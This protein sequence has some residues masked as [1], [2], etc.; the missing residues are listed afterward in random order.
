MPPAKRESSDRKGPRGAR[1]RPGLAGEGLR[2]P[3]APRR[4]PGWP[5]LRRRGPR[6]PCSLSPAPRL[7]SS[8]GPRAAQ[9]TRRSE[10]HLDPRIAVLTL[11][12]VV[13][14]SLTLFGA[15]RW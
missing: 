7:P 6:E 13:L 3:R 2:T 14:A 12:Y 8:W 5:P 11:Y 1:D 9:Y 15:H 10:G 4:A